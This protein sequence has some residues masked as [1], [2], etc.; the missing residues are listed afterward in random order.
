MMEYKG[1]RAAVTFDDEA[2][3][4]HGEVT[5]TRDVIIFEGTSVVELRQEFEFSIDDYLRVC[6]E[7][8]RTP[9]KPYSGKIP[10][11]VPPEVHRAADAAA[12]AQGKSL[13][14]WIT[15]AVTR[16]IGEQVG[17]GRS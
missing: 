8:G 1:Y 4:F 13:N 17:H 2:G 7:R 9:D 16:E 3:V 10:L 14:A 5:G 6:E 12:K 15:E 11:R